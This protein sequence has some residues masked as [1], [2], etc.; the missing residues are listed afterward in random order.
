[1]TQDDLVKVVKDGDKAEAA[2]F[3]S[4][5]PVIERI[6]LKTVGQYPWIDLDETRQ[7]LSVVVPSIIR[8]YDPEKASTD[9]SKYAYFRLYFEA[10]D[11]CREYDPLGIKWPQKSEEMYPTFSRLGDKAFEGWEPPADEIVIEEEDE[12]LT[13]LEQHLADLAFIKSEMTRLGYLPVKPKRKPR[14]PRKYKVPDANRL[15]T[16]VRE[17]R[18]CDG[19][20]LLF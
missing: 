5:I 16:F 11:C 2:L 14:R 1:M 20:P 18:G 19:Q 8:K 6:A 10:K 17:R 4:L 13:E 9:F 7:K 15:S 3:E 12:P